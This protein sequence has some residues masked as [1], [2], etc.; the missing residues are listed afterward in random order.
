MN[1][2]SIGSIHARARAQQRGICNQAIALVLVH[3]DRETPVGSRC[4]AITLS[5]KMAQRLIGQGTDPQLAE[6][7]TKLAL[8]VGSSGRLVTVLHQLGTRSRRYRHR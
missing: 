1:W 4:T 6:R 3:A 7:G 2:P 8:V 5:R